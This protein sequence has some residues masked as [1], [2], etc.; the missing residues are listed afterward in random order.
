MATTASADHLAPGLAAADGPSTPVRSVKVIRTGSGAGHPEHVYGTRKP[1]LWWIFT[2]P[3]SIELPINVYV[4]E[5]D[6]G[7]MLFD[8][9]MDRAVVTD[10]DYW[11][12]PI[13]GLFM[14][15]I[16]RW[17]IGPEDTLARQLDLAGYSAADVRKAVV[18]HLHADHVGGIGDIP[19]ADLYVSSEAWE[20]ML[21]PHPEREMVLRRDIDI[22]GARWHRFTFEA[23]DDPA[24][25]PFSAA[26]DLMGDGSMMI[27]PTPGHL[28][29]SVS[30]LVRRSH[31]APVLLI[32]DLTYAE[33][34]LDHDRVPGTGDAA[35]LRASFSSVRELRDRTP[36]LVIL[37]AHDWDA[38]DKLADGVSA[39]V[40]SR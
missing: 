29:G 28:P 2:S 18:S 1:A 6:E 21:G 35:Q 13:T 8:T 32:G 24:L 36:G 25:A 5:H 34:L 23:T 33:E 11:P 38:A 39:P 19:G 17:N 20:H 9:G 22:P 7:L 37:P 15:H 16:F 31:A 30:M 14:R 26:Y 4:I 10:P 40:P 3:R 12:D 27:L